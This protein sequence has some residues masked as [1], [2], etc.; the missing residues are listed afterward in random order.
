MPYSRARCQSSSA[1][2]RQI[3]KA[4]TSNVPSLVAFALIRAEHEQWVTSTASRRM[5]KRRHWMEAVRWMVGAGLRKGA[6]ATT[7]RV[8][9]DIAARMHRSK[10]G[11]VAYCQ[12]GMQTRLHLS[13]RCI[14]HHVA[15]LR[16][17]GL[18]AWVERGSS[19]RNALRA[20]HGEHFGPNIGFRRSATIYAP[21]APPVW[22]DAM[23]HR[24]DGTG[25]WAR[26]CGVTD[27]GREQAIE[28]VQARQKAR[29]R[30][31]VDN[32]GSCTPSVVV[33]KPRTTS[34]SRGTSKDTPRKRAE[35][36]P[37]HRPKRESR[38]KGSSGWTP[39][40][41]AYAIRQAQ[42]VRLHTW[43]T[44]GSCVRQ[45]AFALRPLF[46]AG[47]S[48]EDCAR[49]LARWAVPLRPRHVASYV[50]SEIRRR[51][52][53]GLLYLPDGSVKPYRQVPVRETSEQERLAAMAQKWRAEFG[54]AWEASAALRRLCRERVVA[55]QTP[56]RRRDRRP[57]GLDAAR[58]DRVLLTS[59][60]IELLHSRFARIRSCED[61]WAEVGERAA[62][63]VRS[64][65]WE[66]A[67]A[68]V[69]PR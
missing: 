55:Q 18:L 11:T 38:S 61:L 66:Y 6:N 51:A 20:R 67:P 41:T 22:D 25:Y 43:W 52:N 3:D 31:A 8:A 26:Q 10:D 39:R 35:Q 19:M 9:E 12:A 4:S 59:A 34:T 42:F 33:P 32:S 13:A 47:W 27:E 54:P 65:T 21:V 44:Q 63:R 16:E 58:P 62:E 17:L 69:E 49:E 36:S 48:G 7:L 53:E 2:R 37:D 1:A 60:E 50:T 68:V 24:I 15:I 28:A 45:L 46:R 23:G 29:P 40:Q 5:R 30:S 64:G 57:R 14:A 56:G